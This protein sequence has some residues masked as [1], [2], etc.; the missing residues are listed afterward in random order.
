MEIDEALRAHLLTKTALTA[1]IGQRIVPDIIDG[2]ALPCV[3]Y[4][5]VSDPKE[6]TYGGIS[7]L[8]GPVF[9]FGAYAET[10]SGAKAIAKQIKAAL[11]D[12][13]GTLSGLVVQYI[14]LLNEMSSA[15]QSGE[16]T[17]KLYVEDLE[18]EINYERS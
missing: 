4:I 17:K 10:K 15:E 7:K 2:V 8:E 11:S 5:K 1:L 14:K 12:Y 16:N 18:F 13:S 3:A 6:H 9:Q